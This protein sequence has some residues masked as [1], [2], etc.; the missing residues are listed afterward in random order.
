MDR[1]TWH[2]MKTYKSGIS[3]YLF[4][5]TDLQGSNECVSRGWNYGIN[6]ILEPGSMNEENIGLDF[7]RTLD[8]AKAACEKWLEERLAQDNA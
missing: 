6:V 2:E 7:A 5:I 4:E 3:D 1:L 8:D